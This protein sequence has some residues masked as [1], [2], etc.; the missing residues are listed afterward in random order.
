MKYFFLPY[1][2]ISF[3]MK[4]QGQIELLG[5]FKNVFLKVAEI[6]ETKWKSVNRISS[7]ICFKE[8]K[9]R[10]VEKWMSAHQ[11]SKVHEFRI[12]STFSPHSSFNNPF[13][14]QLNMKF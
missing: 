10:R 12:S 5:I 4:H 9:L 14:I 8:N 7:N 13:N 1:V 6:E 11:V 3:S 2:G